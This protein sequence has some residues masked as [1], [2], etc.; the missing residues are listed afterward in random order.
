MP[1]RIVLLATL[2]LS[3]VILPGCPSAGLGA[4]I[5]LIDGVVNSIGAELAANGDVLPVSGLQPFGGTVTW[6]RIS[7][8]EILFRQTVANDLWIYY[9]T[10]DSDTTMSGGWMKVVGNGAGSGGLWS[11]TKQ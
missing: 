4:W 8:S 2:I 11:A 6:S 3:L 1:I 5:V 7:D 10:L 9:G